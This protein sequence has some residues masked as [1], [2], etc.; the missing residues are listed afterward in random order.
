ML[1][2]CTLPQARK[3]PSLHLD[4][5]SRT[6]HATEHAALVVQRYCTSLASTVMSAVH[7]LGI[8]FGFPCLRCNTQGFFCGVVLCALYTTPVL[9]QRHGISTGRCTPRLCVATK[10]R[11]CVATKTRPLDRLG[12]LGECLSMPVCCNRDAPVCYNEDTPVCCIRN[13]PA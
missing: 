9:Q 4:L 5:Q 7:T 2:N 1:L 3:T 6:L 8:F 13:V 11:L 10:T 12:Q